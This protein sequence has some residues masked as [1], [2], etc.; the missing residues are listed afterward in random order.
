MKNIAKT[1]MMS[2]CAVLAGCGMTDPW[3]EWSDEGQFPED[4][5]VPSEVKAALCAADGWKMTYNNVNFYYAFSDED[6]VSCTSD[7]LYAATDAAYHF[8]WN[9][10]SSVMLT[11]EGSGHLAYLSDN[12]F[13]DTFVI[14]SYSAEQVV[15]A[16]E[17]GTAEVVMTPVTSEEF[18]G[19]ED[20]KGIII[21]LI[22]AN[23]MNGVI[24]AP[25]GRFLAHYVIDRNTG[26]SIR[27]DII[28]D[29]VLTHESVT[30][31][32]DDNAAV[33]L[34]SPVSVAGT[35]ISEITFDLSAQNGAV[36]GSDLQVLPN[37]TS[38]DFFVGREYVEATRHTIEPGNDKGDAC[39]AI[40]NE[41]KANAG[42]WATIEINERENR[43]LVFCPGNTD[44]SRWYTGFYGCTDIADAC[45]SQES[46][47]LYMSDL[48]GDMLG[49]GGDVV[50]I[51]NIQEDFPNF[52]GAFSHEDGLYVVREIVGGTSYLYFISPTTDSWYKGQH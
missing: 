52:L 20:S 26:N 4:R 27:F 43:P 25:D 19:V 6:Q 51:T 40:W 13:G 50:N 35:E 7:L 22:G 5:M 33:H 47:L 1:L 14:T 28:A 42:N 18:A 15:C 2:F 37:Y 8:N 45:S 46:D 49:L 29:R 41:L 21:E 10:S 39:D 12:E 44:N 9:E 48:R 32:I 3:E 11:I 24:N 36:P 16:N 17:A 23:L 30:V 38:R 31:T 34:S